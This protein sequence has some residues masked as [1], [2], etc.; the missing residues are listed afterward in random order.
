[1]TTLNKEMSVGQLVAE[2]PARSRVFEN[3]AIDYCCAGKRTLDDACRAKGVDPAVVLA[4]LE[5]ADADGPDDAINPSDMTMT[6]LADHIEQTHH[7]F[8]REELPRLTGLTQKV[9]TAHGDRYPWL[10]DVENTYADLVAELE[11]HMQKEEQI[12]FPMIREL[13][14][15]GGRRG[16]SVGSPIAVMEHEH[17]N[18]GNALR[19]LRELTS[20]FTPPPDAC[21]SFRAMLDGLAALEA[22]TH[23]HIHKEN[24]VLFVRAAEAEARQ[25]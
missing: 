22:N 4:E 17:D 15:Q 24:N 18:A 25:G 21:N 2:R 6:D 11:P 13:E 23:E 8:L 5:A 16:G 9:A 12:L 19:R 10:E 3:H 1:M 20:D 14:R 7:V